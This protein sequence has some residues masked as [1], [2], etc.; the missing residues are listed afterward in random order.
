MYCMVYY[1]TVVCSLYKTCLSSSLPWF[2]RQGR[3]KESLRGLKRIE[4]SPAKSALSHPVA[5]RISAA[6]RKGAM[7][8]KQSVMTLC[9]R[10]TGNFVARYLTSR[11]CISCPPTPPPPPATASGLTRNLASLNTTTITITGGAAAS[12]PRR[13]GR[14]TRQAVDPTLRRVL[15]DVHGDGQA[16]LPRVWKREPR[17]RIVL[18][19]R[20]DRDD[21]P[22]PSQESQG[23]PPRQ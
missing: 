3:T 8:Y 13:H 12:I 19:K 15:Q 16:L 1:V 20:Q 22:A 18:R 14:A 21:V 23:Q 2:A 17:P 6:R 9:W 10:T 4:I 7:R 11:V 5:R